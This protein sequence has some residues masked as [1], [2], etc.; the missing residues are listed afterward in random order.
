MRLVTLPTYLGDDLNEIILQGTY[1]K[2]Q[3]EAKPDDSRS[4]CSLSYQFVVRKQ[5][6]QEHI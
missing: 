4:V 2:A 5:R 1:I 3:G 6:S